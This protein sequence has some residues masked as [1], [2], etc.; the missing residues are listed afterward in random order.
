MNVNHVIEN[1]NKKM[2]TLVQEEFQKFKLAIIDTVDRIFEESSTNFRRAYEVEQEKGVSRLFQV[3]KELEE[4]QESLSGLEKEARS[5]N[6]KAVSGELASKD[7]EH[8][9]NQLIS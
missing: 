5:H 4:I 6:W 2:T 9:L 7:V 3:R 8:R 1:F